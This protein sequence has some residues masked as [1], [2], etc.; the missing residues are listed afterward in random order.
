LGDPYLVSVID[1]SMSQ[2][3]CCKHTGWRSG[4]WVQL[5][6]ACSG[7]FT[8]SR[9]ERLYKT[10]QWDLNKTSTRPAH[11]RPC[12]VLTEP[13]RKGSRWKLKVSC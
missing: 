3:Q 10:I 4:N 1:Q 11:V 5:P 2:S 13:L 6:R 7:V 8:I 9:R 12:L